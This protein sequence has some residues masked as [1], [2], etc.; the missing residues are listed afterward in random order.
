MSNIV[1]TFQVDGGRIRLGSLT[2]S[3]YLI[4]R[5]EDSRLA[6]LIYGIPARW[7]KPTS[8]RIGYTGYPYQCP[9]AYC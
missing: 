9:S 2:I 3:V 1:S 8:S 4:Y 5:L 7:Y 6:R